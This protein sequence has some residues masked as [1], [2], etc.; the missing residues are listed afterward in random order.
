METKE[1]FKIATAQYEIID[2]L[3]NLAIWQLV[4]E[5][6]AHQT[7]TESEIKECFADA[8]KMTKE[9]LVNLLFERE[10]NNEIK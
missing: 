1:D 8:E 5:L 2:R 4:D 7:V 3:R 6:R 9:N 10:W